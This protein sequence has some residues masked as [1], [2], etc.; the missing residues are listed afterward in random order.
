MKRVVLLV[1]VLGVFWP[2]AANAAVPCR[3]RIYNDWYKDGK[4]ATNYPITCYRDAIKHAGP[5]AKIYS[6]LIDDIKAAMAAAIARKLHHRKEP[7]QV[8]KGL[9]ALTSGTKGGKGRGAKGR[10]SKTSTT[11]SSNVNQTT[12][13]AIGPTSAG[14]GGG[15]GGIPTPILILGGLAILLVAVGAAGAGAKRFRKPGPPPAA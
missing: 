10:G 9:S 12:T 8:G 2:T 15:G 11:S 3:N 4:I 7:A 14:S 6:S 1:L 5:D 13:V